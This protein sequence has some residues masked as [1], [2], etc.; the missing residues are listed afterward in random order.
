MSAMET[1]AFSGAARVSEAPTA[2]SAPL[3]PGRRNRG[4]IAGI[5]EERR[6]EREVRELRRNSTKKPKKEEGE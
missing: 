2:G 6:R 5:M 1:M 3:S 4:T